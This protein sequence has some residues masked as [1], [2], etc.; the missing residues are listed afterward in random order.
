MSEEVYVDLNISG[1]QKLAILPDAEYKVRIL[2]A[3][4]KEAK[5]TGRPYI[6]I[7]MEA[8]GHGDAE[9][10]YE[11]LFMPMEGDEERNATRMNNRIAECAECFGLDV[12]G[13]A[14]LSDW[15][16]KVGFVNLTTEEYEGEKRNVVAR[17]GFIA[18]R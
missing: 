10:I 18:K 5:N 15:E 3:T 13:K 1:V 2:G 8:E 17:K 16:G 7:R 14:K 6:N 9:E 12:T 11:K 4:L